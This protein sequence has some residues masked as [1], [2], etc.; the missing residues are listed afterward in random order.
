MHGQEVAPFSL[1]CRQEVFVSRGLEER[2]TSQAWWQVVFGVIVTDA[3]ST[4]EGDLEGACVR[5]ASL[6]TNADPV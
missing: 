6:A 5:R 4:L 2:E 1:H 3:D